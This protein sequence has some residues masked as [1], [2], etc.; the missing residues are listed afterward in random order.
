MSLRMKS[1]FSARMLKKCFLCERFSHGG[2]WF[3][4]EDFPSLPEI[5]LCG[6]CSVK[7]DT[8]EVAVKVQ[9]SLLQKVQ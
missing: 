3:T 5:F 7:V 2:V 4:L 1:N 9:T 8:L 6:V